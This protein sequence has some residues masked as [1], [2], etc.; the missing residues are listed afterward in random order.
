M[1]DHKENEAT[2]EAKYWAAKAHR[3]EFES[4]YFPQKKEA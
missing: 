1:I 4:K 3:E 2:Y